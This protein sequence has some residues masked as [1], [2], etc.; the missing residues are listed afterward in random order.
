MIA[1]VDCR[2]VNSTEVLNSSIGPYLGI[3]EGIRSCHP[4][5]SAK[6]TR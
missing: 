3:A 1:E 2:S 5:K 4:S 6:L